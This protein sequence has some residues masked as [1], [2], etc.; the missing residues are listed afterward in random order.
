MIW[1]HHKIHFT[2]LEVARNVWRRHLGAVSVATLQSYL[3]GASV[4]R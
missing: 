4:E 3:D 1:N 2:H